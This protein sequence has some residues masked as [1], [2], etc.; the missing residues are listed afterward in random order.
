MLA[1]MVTRCQAA[2]F[3]ARAA[4][5]DSWGGAHAIA[6]FGPHELMHFADTLDSLVYFAFLLKVL[7]RRPPLCD[8]PT[9][10]A[11]PAWESATPDISRSGFMPAGV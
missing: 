3:A 2:G 8:N 11:D 5:A 9:A 4:I 7:I 10:V 1:D 6:R